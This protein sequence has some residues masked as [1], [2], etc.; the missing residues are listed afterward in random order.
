MLAKLGKVYFNI[1]FHK[2]L[3]R[4]NK[5]FFFW[6]WNMNVVHSEFFLKINK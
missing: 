5:Q 1:T 3:C 2:G 4:R 6:E